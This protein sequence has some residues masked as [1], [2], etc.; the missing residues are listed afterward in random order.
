MAVYLAVDPD[1]EELIFD[2]VMPYRQD[3]YWYANYD[4]HGES[5]ACITLPQG[6]IAKLIGKELTWDDEPY[7]LKE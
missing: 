6:S 2:Q 3:G 4:K 7:E 1:G 5:Y